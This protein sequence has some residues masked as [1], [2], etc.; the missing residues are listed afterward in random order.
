MRC[1]NPAGPLF[2]LYYVYR[3]LCVS[4]GSS[5][6]QIV[7]EC[8]R[9]ELSGA[10][11]KIFSISQYTVHALRKV[12]R[13]FP[14]KYSAHPQQVPAAPRWRRQ[15]RDR[16]SGFLIGST[17]SR[18]PYIIRM[19]EMCVLRCWNPA[20]PFFPRYYVHRSLYVPRY[21]VHR[22]CAPKFVR[23]DRQLEQTSNCCT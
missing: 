1:W 9:G 7:V 19:A 22:L 15:M 3:S 16:V 23:V 14:S 10:H 12:I 21:Y 20:G 11:D 8:K 2:P 13:W 6:G 18:E 5:N 4:I 17:C